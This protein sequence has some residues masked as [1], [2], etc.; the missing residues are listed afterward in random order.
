MGVITNRV[1]LC[2]RREQRLHY[3]KLLAGIFRALLGPVSQG[4]SAA[5]LYAALAGIWFKPPQAPV[6]FLLHDDLGG[7]VCHLWLYNDG[8]SILYQNVV[9]TFSLLEHCSRV[10]ILPNLG[11]P[12]IQDLRECEWRHCRG[13]HPK[14]HSQ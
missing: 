13:I 9:T 4:G 12:R 3:L 1:V 7:L 5:L 14:R 11:D 8:E 10:R 6:K 2:S